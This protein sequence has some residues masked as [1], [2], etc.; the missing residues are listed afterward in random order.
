MGYEGA[1]KGIGYGIHA[2][3]GICCRYTGSLGVASLA[4]RLYSMPAPILHRDLILI[5]KNN[6]HSKA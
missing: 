2:V 5:Y 3:Q 4:T 1:V 6:K